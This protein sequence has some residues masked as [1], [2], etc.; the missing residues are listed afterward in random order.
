MPSCS[1]TKS[2]RWMRANREAFLLAIAFG[3]LAGC[4]SASPDDEAAPSTSE[5]EQELRLFPDPQCPGPIKMSQ[6][7]FASLP[8]GYEAMQATRKSAALWKVLS[9]SEYLAKCRPSSGLFLSGLASLTTV[10][11]MRETLQHS[12]DQLPAGRRKLVHPFGSVATVDFE[13]DPSASTSYTGILA[14]AVAG[15]AR[16]V[17]AVVRLSLG[18][19]DRVIGFTPGM[20]VKFLVDGK[21]SVNV[22]SMNSLMGQGRDHNFFRLPF[23]NEVPESHAG[24]NRDSGLADFLKADAFSL[25]QNL[26]FLPAM[27]QGPNKAT[28][29]FLHVDHVAVRNTDGSLVPEAAR[30]APSHLVFRPNAALTRWWDDPRNAGFDYRDLLRAVPAGSVIYDVYARETPDA[31]EQH[32]GVLRTTSPLVASKWGDFRLFFRHNDYQANE[33]VKR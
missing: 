14:P 28:P 16:T 26:A 23:S 27:A 11:K 30:H 31:P 22:V 2:L 6:M 21:P 29:N 1:L 20:A 18:G 4:S 10:P 13:K 25:G 15:D 3:M 8:S 9:E 12:A 33:D 5:E 17:H 24:L 32:L 19:D 7:P